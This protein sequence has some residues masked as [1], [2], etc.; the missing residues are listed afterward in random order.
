MTHIQQIP[1]HPSILSQG[2]GK[3]GVPVGSPFIEDFKLR[4][5]QPQS[6]R[7]IT[8]YDIVGHF[9]ECSLD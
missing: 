3:G 7:E 4:L 5:A 8:L 2:S 6:L 9:I 1:V